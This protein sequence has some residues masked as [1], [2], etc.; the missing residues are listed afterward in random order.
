[1]LNRSALIVRP[2]EPY[3]KWATALDDS[4]LVPDAVG[5]QTVYLLP[6]W[7]DQKDAERLLK[8]VWSEVFERELHGWCTDQSAWPK[9]RTLKMFK[10]WFKIEMHSM[11]EDLCRDPLHDDELD[12]Q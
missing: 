8:L 2:A 5:E 3:I 9:K 10:D 1:M 11:I 4:G 7:G 12:F 6:E